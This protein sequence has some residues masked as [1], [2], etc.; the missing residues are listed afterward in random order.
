MYLLL[1]KDIGDPASLGVAWK[2][3]EKENNFFFLV[4]YRIG[5]IQG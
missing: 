4:L 5:G 2:K 1:Q 3:M